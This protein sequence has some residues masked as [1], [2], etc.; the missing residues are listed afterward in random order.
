AGMHRDWF[1]RVEE[2][3]YAA[4]DAFVRVLEG[5]NLAL[6]SLVDGLA[7]QTIADAATRSL[8]SGTLVRLDG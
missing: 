2:T 6:P 7:A 1:D 3:Y 4:L 8:Q 5:E